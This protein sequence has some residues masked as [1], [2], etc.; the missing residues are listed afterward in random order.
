MAAEGAKAVVPR[1]NIKSN[2]EVAK[3]QIF[4]G[5]TEKVLDF[6]MACRLY[7]R[8]RIREVVEEEQIQ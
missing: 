5:K 8:I 2:V 3:P 4:N 7:I 1:P 6:L